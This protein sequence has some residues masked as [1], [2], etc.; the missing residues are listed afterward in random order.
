MVSIMASIKQISRC[1]TLYRAEAL[2]QEKLGGYQQSYLLT[3][4]ENP[5]ITQDELAQTIHVNKSNAAR[6]AAALEEGG[7]IIR[8]PG[9]TDRRQQCAYPTEK[10]K[11]LYPAVRQVLEEW[12]EQLLEGFTE[13]ERRTLDEMLK[14]ISSRAAKL[15]ARP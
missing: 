6:Q 15:I 4:C 10:G 13:E 12:S 11:R 14:K 8:L 3:I 2:E 5:G 7:F 9:K 1:S